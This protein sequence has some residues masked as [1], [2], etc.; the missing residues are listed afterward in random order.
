[1]KNLPL[2]ITLILSFN[3]TSQQKKKTTYT[4]KNNGYYYTKT[5]KHI[6]SYFKILAK[7]FETKDSIYGINAFVFKDNYTFN[8]DDDFVGVFQGNKNNY[9]TSIKFLENYLSVNSTL[10]SNGNTYINNN[11]FSLELIS[12]S[13]DITNKTVENLIVFKGKFTDD[14][15]FIILT[16]NIYKT[17]NKSKLFKSY[18]I[19]KTYLFKPFL[20]KT[21]KYFNENLKEISHKEFTDKVMSDNYLKIMKIEDSTVNKIIVKRKIIDSLSI[22]SYN[23][24]KKQIKKVTKSEINNNNTIV[25]NFP[26]INCDCPLGEMNKILVKSRKKYIRKIKRKKNINQFFIYNN[27][28]EARKNI[29]IFDIHFDSQNLIK[30]MFFN[31]HFDLD[32]FVIIK[33]NGNYYVFKG[34]FS[35]NQILEKL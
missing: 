33:P 21:E 5:K 26:I 22:S 24:L 29:N 7:N 34:E 23:L 25:L 32:G 35:Y 12:K 13:I 18:N 3:L 8:T 6:N 2:I 17:Q 20:I 28:E 31:S 27:K 10:L 19:H 9:I 14:N 15:N 16:K 11:F 4:F 1:M 30:N